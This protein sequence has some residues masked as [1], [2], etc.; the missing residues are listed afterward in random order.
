MERRRMDMTCKTLQ[1]GSLAS[2]GSSPGHMDIFS[3]S[4]QASAP[5]DLPGPALSESVMHPHGVTSVIQAA[6]AIISW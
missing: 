2:C 4:S 1:S 5:L 6:E 3:A